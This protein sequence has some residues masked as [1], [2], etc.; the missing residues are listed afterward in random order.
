MPPLLDDAKHDDIPHARL[1]SPRVGPK[2]EG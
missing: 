1:G 2:G